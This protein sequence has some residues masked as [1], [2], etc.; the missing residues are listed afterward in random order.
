MDMDATKPVIAESQIK[1]PLTT[2]PPETGRQL[3][4]DEVFASLER[5]GRIC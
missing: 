2:G 1:A 5:A 3:T 4:I